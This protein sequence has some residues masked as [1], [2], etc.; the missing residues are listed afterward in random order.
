[1]LLIFVVSEQIDELPG[2]QLSKAINYYVCSMQV[3]AA[4]G[5][6]NSHNRHARGL[7]R[8]NALDSI[9]DNYTMIGTE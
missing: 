8:L 7:A 3:R 5:S 6:C 2:M 4:S 1:M 9:F